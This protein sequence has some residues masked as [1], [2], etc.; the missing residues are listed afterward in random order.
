MIKD[1]LHTLTDE[2][3]REVATILLKSST[4]NLFDF[5]FL[6]I[7]RN[8]YE[9]HHGVDAEETISVYFKGTLKNRDYEKSGWKDKEVIINLTERDRYH[10]Y[11]YFS[12]SSRTADLPVHHYTNNEYVSNY[13]EAIEYLQKIEIL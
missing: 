1:K 6:K 10:D 2:Q 4:S 3:A 7:R 9:E 5:E 12:A 8:K 11:P 13:I